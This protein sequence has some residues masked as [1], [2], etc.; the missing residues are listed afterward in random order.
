MTPQLAA[1]YAV[2]RHIARSAAR[3]FYYG[4]LVLPRDKRN[5]MC[6]V[7]AFMRH[8]DD[9]SDDPG[10]TSREREDRLTEWRNA[11]HRGVEGEHT[12]DP[13]LLAAADTQRRFRIPL[14]LFDRLVEG[15]AMDVPSQPG[16]T[17]RYPTFEDLRRYCYHVAS[18]VG[19]ICIK[20]FGY[21]DPA[22]EQLAEQCG[23]AFQLTNIIRDVKEDAAMGRIYLP[24]EDLE[25]FGHSPAELDPAR[26]QN[27]F[28][29][30]SFRPLLEF[31][32]DR[33]RELYRAAEQ[34]LPMIDEESR[35]A[36][37]VLVEIYRRLLNK[38]AARGYNVF[39]KKIRLSRREKLSVLARGLWR[40]LQ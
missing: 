15:T 12:D 7:Y 17:L 24:A 19:L 4:F 3:N 38:V 18:V 9:L 10:L 26:L 11:L 39:G 37:W 35:P 8:S 22:A 27:G 32:A 20:I 34:L 21:R 29:A 2:C 33:A 40:R 25:R 30:S 14:A 36:L 31:E 1:A 28:D 13:V 6:A 16:E 5:A 23:L